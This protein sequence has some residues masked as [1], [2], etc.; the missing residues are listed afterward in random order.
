MASVVGVTNG[1]VRVGG[2]QWSDECA[3]RAFRGEFHSSFTPGG[4]KG[5]KRTEVRATAAAQCATDAGTVCAGSITVERGVEGGGARFGAESL[6]AAAG[7][8]AFVAARG[9]GA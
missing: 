2:G 3:T 6:P 5:P 8:S 1:L 9:R 4:A 7:A